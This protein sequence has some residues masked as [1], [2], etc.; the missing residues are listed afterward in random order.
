[1]GRLNNFP[2]N[3]FDFNWEKKVIAG[4]QKT[5]N[6]IKNAASPCDAIVIA[7]NDD[8]SGE[9]DLLGWEIVNAINWQRTVFRIRFA[10][11]TPQNFKTALLNKVDVTDQ[12]NQGG[13]LESLGRERFDY[14]SMQL[15]RI[16]LSIARQAGFNVR[17]MRFGRQKSTIID[18]I[19][20]QLKARAEYV[21]K[22]FYEVRFQDN[23]QNIF[24]RTDDEA[25]N[26]KFTLENDAAMEKGKYANSQIII[27][28]KEQKRQQPPTLLDLSHLSI[29][30]GK[31]GFSSET[32]L[33]TYQKMYENNILSY[34]RTEDRKIT[35]AQFDQ[36]LPLADQIAHVVGIDPK[37]LTHRTIRK[38]YLVTAAAHGAN[39]PGINVPS[40]LDAIESEY[41]KCGREIYI[42]AVKSYLSILGEDSIYEQQKAHLAAYPFFT[43]TINV[44]VAQNYKLIFDDA[45]LNDENPDNPTRQFS[46]EAFPIVYQG[47]NPKPKKPTHSFIINFL[48]RY[49][50]GHGATQESTL[51][52]IAKGRNALITNT[53]ETYSLTYPG[54]LQAIIATGT[55]IASPKVTE[56]LQEKMD[57]VKQGKFDYRNVP[58][59]INQIVKYDLPIEQRNAAN[60]A[61][62][63]SP[64][65]LKMKAD[66]EAKNKT[67]EKA[68]G[69]WCGQ[70]V[71]INKV[72]N[73]YTFSDSELQQLFNDQKIQIIT[74]NGKITG[75]LERQSYKN[76][77]FIGF[78]PEFPDKSDEYITGIFTPT[79]KE[80]SFKKKFST[81]IFSQ[82]EITQL[83]LGNEIRFSFTSA[84][85]KLCT[86]SGKLKKYVYQGKR[87]F[88]FKGKFIK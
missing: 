83:L 60:L 77:E 47:Q 7:T 66:Y 29:L 40:S 51:A 16:A 69:I 65:L 76:H 46:T 49:G 54:L 11:E 13:Y 23:N 18:K 37:L 3:L 36:L 42:A 10:D 70:Q 14:A 17:S 68:S 71:T 5:L 32:F 21:K 45:E 56:R 59:L 1:M 27:D 73:S 58:F 12:M 41:G 20:Q 55:M 88:G 86:V 25:E 31:K 6:T 9:G 62:T 38:K 79:N 44:P 30:V 52:E 74:P 84:K 39:R 48:D 15:S 72:W 34:P 80:V 87:H 19:F 50:I 4:S 2:W 67:K 75:K 43:C 82:D 8:P 64:K 57:L 78:K 63:A 22:P 35:Q 85:G 33:A 53:K 81:H 26:H 61:K 28:S 24:K